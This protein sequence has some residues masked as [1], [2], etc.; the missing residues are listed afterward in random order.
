[1]KS[2]FTP[3]KRIP[4]AENKLKTST[5]REFLSI[6]FGRFARAPASDPLVTLGKY[7]LPSSSA[8]YRQPCC[9]EEAEPGLHRFFLAGDRE[10]FPE[11]LFWE[12]AG[13]W[14]GLPTTRP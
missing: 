7:N 8:N 13:L 12:V 3:E 4:D 14:G 6:G 5:P 2:D 9:Y 1:M 11:V 10:S